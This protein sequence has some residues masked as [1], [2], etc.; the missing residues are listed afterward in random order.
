MGESAK[1]RR[2]RGGGR[3][4]K[5]AFLLIYRNIKRSKAYH[6]LTVYARA[7]L[8]ELIDRYT[9][10]NN[11]MIGFGVREAKYELRCGTSTVIRA[12]QQLDDAGLA[13][14]LII[15]DRR[16]RKASE[17]RLM[18]LRCDKTGD[19]PVSNWEQR[20]PHNEVRS[21]NAKDPEEELGSP[22]RSGAGTQT[23]NSSMKDSAMR[24]A[25][26][27]HI[28]IYQVQGEERTCTD[29]GST[30][31]HSETKASGQNNFGPRNASRRAS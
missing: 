10:N 20:P 22:R 27:A 23:Q 28:D 29:S 21:G 6:S 17:W 13:R 8:L 24:S 2:L 3:K 7:L 4:S 12:M 25:G 11:G 15:G 1:A 9:G 5:R 19:L 18:W 30:S 31:D 26:G 14:P 16:G